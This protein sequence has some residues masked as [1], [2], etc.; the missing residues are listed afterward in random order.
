MVGDEC[1]FKYYIYLIIYPMTYFLWVKSMESLVVYKWVDLFN[2]GMWRTEQATRGRWMRASNPIWKTVEKKSRLHPTYLKWWVSIPCS[3]GWLPA[4]KI[5]PHKR[6][7]SQAEAKWW[8]AHT[9]LAHSHKTHESRSEK[10]HWRETISSTRAK[11]NTK[12][13]WRFIKVPKQTCKARKA[14]AWHK[15]VSNALQHWFQTN[16]C[17]GA[18]QIACTIIFSV[19]AKQQ[20]AEASSNKSCTCIEKQEAIRNKPVS[21]LVL[22]EILAKAIN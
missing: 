2:R 13:K 6:Q 19:Q 1:M 7:N 12:Q 5:L 22:F 16:T 11:H 15:L 14:V 8:K 9:K 4:L 21:T 17:K 3:S 20:L 10:N 18:T